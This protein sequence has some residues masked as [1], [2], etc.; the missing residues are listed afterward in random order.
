MKLTLQPLIENAIQH[1]LTHKRSGGEI[2]LRGECRDGDNFLYVTDNGEGVAPEEL[3]KL[4]ER[5]KESSVSGGSHIG[6]RNV[7]QR[8]KLIFGEEYGL[9]LSRS[10]EGGL[11]V[12][13]RFRSL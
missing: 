6:L 3:E 5:L 11:C 2:W 1:G 8:L 13:V 12:T 9:S 10:G 7:D 4:T